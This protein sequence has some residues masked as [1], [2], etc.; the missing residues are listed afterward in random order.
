M[1]RKEMVDKQLKAQQMKNRLFAE[2][3]KRYDFKYEFNKLY[4]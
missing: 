3:K 2:E 4:F 1:D